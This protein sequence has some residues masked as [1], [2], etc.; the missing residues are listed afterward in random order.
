MTELRGPEPEVQIGNLAAEIAR[1]AAM[2]GAI[3]PSNDYR[4]VL[5]RDLAD[6]AAE[7]AGWVCR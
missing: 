3:W 5:A 2:V 7:L 1:E 6:K 4:C